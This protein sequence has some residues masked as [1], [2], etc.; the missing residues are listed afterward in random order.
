[1]SF[2]LSQHDLQ[3]L[4]L[5]MIEAETKKPTILVII[6]SRREPSK[7]Y[8][9]QLEQKYNLVFWVLDRNVVHDE[10]SKRIVRLLRDNRLDPDSVVGFSEEPSLLAAV[11]ATQLGSAYTSPQSIC[12]AQHKAV[13]AQ[14]A[15]KIDENCPPTIGIINPDQ[16]GIDLEYP[17][18]IR[19]ARG[20]VSELA[21][22]IDSEEDLAKTLKTVFGK[23]RTLKF[24]RHACETYLEKPPPVSSFLLQP[25]IEAPQ[26]TVDG[27]VYKNA[28]RILGIAESIYDERR[29]SFQRFDLLTNFPQA[30]QGDLQSLLERTIRALGFDNS[31]FSVEFFLASG[32]EIILIEFNTRASAVFTNIYSERYQS[33]LIDMMIQISVGN[34][35]NVSFK[36]ESRLA[37]NCVLRV[38]QDHYIKSIPTPEEVEHLKEKYGLIDIDILVE[39]GKKLSDYKQDSYSYRYAF[40][41]I[42]GNSRQEILDKLGKVRTELKF[43]LEPV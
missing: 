9:K 29:E 38:K 27:F 14:I 30:V 43:E 26:F 39:P 3:N 37:S 7:L 10:Q 5:G 21:Y 12:R 1:M 13:F 23:N 36:D 4:Q 42:A 11:L 20:S 15:R 35:P 18:F 33:S 32:K 41:D 31:N 40:V 28:V 8:F 16:T 25:F 24:W 2:I 34:G 17:V 6:N 22:R 19:P